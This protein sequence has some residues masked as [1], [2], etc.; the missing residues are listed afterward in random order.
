MGNLTLTRFFALHGFVL[1]GTI[2]GLVVVHLYLFRLHGV[3]TAW[4]RSVTNCSKEQRTLLAGAGLE[5]R[6]RRPGACC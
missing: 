4:W 2:I 3:T 5:R 6:R 1:P